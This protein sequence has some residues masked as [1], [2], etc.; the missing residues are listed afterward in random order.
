MRSIL[1]GIT[2]IQS[3]ASQP[4]VRRADIGLLSIGLL[5]TDQ[6]QYPVFGVDPADANHLLAADAASETMNASAD[7]GQHWFELPLL[8]KAVTDSGRFRVAVSGATSVN[9]IAWDPTNSCHILVGTMQNGVIRSTDGGL[10]WKRV[11]GS[12][13]ATFITSFYHPPSGAIWMSTYGRGLWNINVDRS[14]PATGRCAFPTPPGVVGGRPDTLIVFPVGGGAS[15]PFEGTSDSIVCPTCTVLAVHV[16]WI[17]D[18]AADAKGVSQVDISNGTL[19]ALDKRGNQVPAPVPNAYRTDEGESLRRLVGR[20]IAGARRVRAIVLNGTQLVA[21]VLGRAELPMAG[22]REPVVLVA[23]P[24]SSRSPS[25]V[26]SGDSALVRGYAFLPGAG[27]AGVEIRVDEVPRARGV[28]VGRDGT[29]AAVVQLTEGPG[30]VTVRAL[31]RD[32]KRLTLAQT[33]VTVVAR[34]RD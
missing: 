29:F 20:E 15:R 5:N 2:R 3:V 10:T 34:E 6:A 32:G 25:L 11:V 7:G 26:V 9:A 24:G 23:S 16:G 8:T 1:N 13:H 17:T 12:E 30:R 14:P 28:S 4:V 22:V 27:D 18:V 19:V 33:I 31:Q 21:V